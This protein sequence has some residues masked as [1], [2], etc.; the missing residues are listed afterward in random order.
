M[1]D[2][3]EQRRQ[4]LAKARRV[5]IKVG[6]AVL[7]SAKGLDLRAITRLADQIASLHDR[8]RLRR[9]VQQAFG[10]QAGGAAGR[11]HFDCFGQGEVQ[12]G[13]GL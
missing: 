13:E 9:H 1:T 11:A 12:L 4:V 2:W 7:T 8:G 5:L 6:S 3:R 10:G